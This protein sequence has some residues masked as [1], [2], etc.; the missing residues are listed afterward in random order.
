MSISIDARK[1]MGI[2]YLMVREWDGYDRPSYTPVFNITEEEIDFFGGRFERF[3]YGKSEHK[4]CIG[5]TN[6]L[7]IEE[8]I[9]WIHENTTGVWSFDIS[10]E[11]PHCRIDEEF[12]DVV[13]IFYFIKEE[14]VVAFK[15]RWT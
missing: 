4:F 5:V 14:D 7:K 2:N 8:T 11:F 12:F 3:K 10:T 15:L 1:Y 6:G 13:W 9:D